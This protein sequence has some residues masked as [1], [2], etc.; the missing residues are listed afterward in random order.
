MVLKRFLLLNVVAVFLLSLTFG[1]VS[2]WFSSQV[3][4]V[5]GSITTGEVSDLDSL[6]LSFGGTQNS[7]VLIL[8]GGGEKKRVN[9]GL[10]E[11]KDEWVTDDNDDTKIGFDFKYLAEFQSSL[12]YSSST[13]SSLPSFCEQQPS[14]TISYPKSSYDKING[15]DQDWRNYNLNN[16]ENL[17]A[18]L[19]IPLFNSSTESIN[20]D[21]FLLEE[22]ISL[23]ASQE[24]N[25]LFSITGLP[26]L[27]NSCSGLRLY[28]RGGD[29]LEKVNVNWFCREDVGLSGEANDK[30]TLIEVPP[31]ERSF[32]FVEDRPDSD[33][34]GSRIL[35]DRQD[36]E[37]NNP[38]ITIQWQDFHDDCKNGQYNKDKKVKDVINFDILNAL[39]VTNLDSPEDPLNQNP[40]DVGSNANTDDV[41]ST[42]NTSDIGGSVSVG[43]SVENT[44]EWQWSGAG[45]GWILCWVFE[46]I[47]DGL[48]GV[49]R[50]VY[51]YLTVEREDYLQEFSSQGQTFTYKDAWVNIRNF[52]TFTIVGTAL[53][54][55]LST[56]L[57]FGFFV[58]YTVKKYLP[59]LILGTILI[60]FSW[61][62]GDLAIQATNQLGNLMGA[63]LYSAFPGAENHGLEDIFDGGGY[64]SL[65][66]G[67]A[68]AG[69]VAYFAGSSWL[70][71]LPIGFTGLIMLFT[72]FLF[73]IA[74]KYLIILGLIL[75]PLGLAF[76]MLP[77]NDRA[78]RFYIKTFFY[79]L[80][81]Y[82]LIVTSIAAGK[83]FSYLILL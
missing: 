10:D 79:L 44:C 15:Y 16:R 81:F 48:E 54:M 76:W 71:L 1:L 22:T 31:F 5:E 24:F 57:D 43:G 39:T 72:G 6:D 60:Q 19:I 27:S 32:I 12:S 34:C 73:L 36:I 69:T 53:F 74:R 80:I 23:D 61:V 14:I 35:V 4:A 59:R 41:G 66:G 67:G 47:S 62:L 30:F 38:L 42:V 83:I 82:P 33:K 63:I 49:E 51:G 21:C 28:G 13:S 26:N 3:S 37:K 58:N 68:A 46:S 65:I 29:D 25:P 8:E 50:I 18:N 56:A 52:M 17:E 64:T 7:L 45:V 77:G 70:L 11:I 2:V 20:D 78:W 75:S 40:P 9:F 55:I